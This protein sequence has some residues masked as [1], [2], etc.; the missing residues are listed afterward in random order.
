MFLN[1]LSRLRLWLKLLVI[2][3]L[4]TWRFWDLKF[5]GSTYSL[6]TWSGLFRLKACN[7]KIHGIPFTD[8]YECVWS[9]TSQY[10]TRCNIHHIALSHLAE[11]PLSRTL[12]EV[13]VIVHFRL[14]QN[15]NHEIVFLSSIS[16][17]IETVPWDRYCR[18]FK[19]H[20]LRLVPTELFL[21]CGQLRGHF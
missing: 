6:H 3:M 8:V 14:F 19:W 10:N 21:V 16:L 9:I 20:R 17:I 13:K 11:P 15:L 18:I 1:R 7:V 12:L 4:T 5:S 2:F